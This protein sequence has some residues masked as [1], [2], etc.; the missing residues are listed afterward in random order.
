MR[1]TVAQIHSVFEFA[2]SGMAGAIARHKTG[3]M[4]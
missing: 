1:A 4:G 2:K 3:S